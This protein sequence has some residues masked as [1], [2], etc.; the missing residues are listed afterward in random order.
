MAG[1]HEGILSEF[2]ITSAE[3]MAALNEQR[4]FLLHQLGNRRWDIDNIEGQV[5]YELI[6]SLRRWDECGRPRL[7]AWAHTVAKNVFLTWCR[8]P[9][10]G[11]GPRR[12]TLVSADALAEEGVEFVALEPVAQ[13]DEVH[14]RHVLMF[15]L[16]EYVLSRPGGADTWRELVTEDYEV[17]GR[18]AAA[19]L[20]QL[21]ELAVDPDG[22]LRRAAGLD[23]DGALEIG[24]VA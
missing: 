10:A 6:R 9:E 11:V 14:A 4:P 7:A 17:R 5:A 22:A 16:Q 3:L 1:A 13:G 2:G 21:I 18:T 20:M 15:R 12:S 24:D 8:S 19:R 23:A